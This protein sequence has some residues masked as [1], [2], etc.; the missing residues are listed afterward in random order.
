MQIFETRKALQAHLT[1]L[2][3]KALIIGL[4]PTMG[5]LHDG[6]LAL[7][8]AARQCCDFVLTTI[9]VNPLQFGPNEDLDKYPRTLADDYERLNSHHCDGVFVPPVSEMYPNGLKKQT[10]VSVPELSRHHCGSSRPGHFDGVCTV[11]TKLFNLTQPDMAFFGEKDFQQLQIIRKMTADLCIPVRIKGVPIVRTESGLAMSSRNTYLDE[12]QLE[13]AP[14]LFQTLKNT[15]VELEK[16][17]TNFPALE[18]EAEEKLQHA[19]FISDYFNISNAKTLEPATADDRSLVILA[20]A[21]LGKTR[22]IDNIQV[23]LHQ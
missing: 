4:V 2:R 6:H 21:W 13:K 14:L 22:L 8:D 9:F 7:V 19:G 17:N 5:N 3:H 12:I 23:S 15:A 10:I 1:P 11:V 18:L 20:A 16:G